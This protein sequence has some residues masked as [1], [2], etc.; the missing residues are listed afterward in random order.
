MTID[1]KPV[2]T[3]DQKPTEET[4]EITLDIP[5]NSSNVLCV[6][7][8][9]KHTADHVTGYCNIGMQYV[10]FKDLKD[11]DP[12]E[13]KLLDFSKLVSVNIADINFSGSF[14]LDNKLQEIMKKNEEYGETYSDKLSNFV[15]ARS[16]L[17]PP[18][19]KYT[20]SFADSAHFFGALML[21]GDFHPEIFFAPKWKF[22]IKFLNN[23]AD[24]AKDTT[25][26][27]DG[28]LMKE[29]T[30]CMKAVILSRFLSLYQNSMPYMSD[31]SKK[32]KGKAFEIGEC[33][34]DIV[35]NQAGDCEDSARFACN[36]WMEIQDLKRKDPANA[37]EA[38][39]DIMKTSENYNLYGI[40]CTVPTLK[41][42]A[43]MT[44]ALRKK[45]TAKED[46]PSLLLVEG[47]NMINPFAYNLK[48]QPRTIKLDDVYSRWV[49]TYSKDFPSLLKM[50]P[51]EK[52]ALVVKGAEVTQG[53]AD[54][55]QSFYGMIAEV[56]DTSEKKMYALST[57][58]KNKCY[59]A[60]FQDFAEGN[61][62]MHEI[63]H[64][65]EE[66]N[67]SMKLLRGLSR[68]HFKLTGDKKNEIFGV[69]FKSKNPSTFPP[70]PLEKGV[71]Y[72]HLF[73]P[74]SQY[75]DEIETL[76]KQHFNSFPSYTTYP[77][78][79]EKSAD[80]FAVFRIEFKGHI[81]KAG[82]SINGSKF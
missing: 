16:P 59:G 14:P 32:K 22:E 23:L 65:E 29:P 2:S 61:V 42:M 51:P 64:N 54:G 57:I 3:P 17:M 52:Q 33:F 26:S 15:H 67:N 18:G 13:S 74:I 53:R 63:Y 12:T 72:L 25:L 38:L 70:V 68:P 1:A 80:G 78:N 60:S 30:H 21:Q 82:S 41:N 7:V 81:S 8:R 4:R 11:L 56:Y 40:L 35:L 43:H 9:W 62:E 49:K 27:F 46:Y 20:R 34:G 58:G 37:N 69:E 66:F 48:M 75:T 39:K 24:V 45:P 44:A 55:A 71:Q 47:T 5:N 79:S 31:V 73:L 36:L 77:M 6:E 28:K 76:L 19:A 50:T 10:Q